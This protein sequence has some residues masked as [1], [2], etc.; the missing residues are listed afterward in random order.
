ML[1]ITHTIPIATVRCIDEFVA[2]VQACSR[3]AGYKSV[4]PSVCLALVP[5]KDS[6]VRQ[7]EVLNGATISRV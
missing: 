2:R 5:K 6:F 3:P 7:K 1:K 4:M